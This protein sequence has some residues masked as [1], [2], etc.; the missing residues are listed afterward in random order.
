VHYQE[1]AVEVIGVLQNL[2]SCGGGVAAI[3]KAQIDADGDNKDMIPALQQAIVVVMDKHSADM[4]DL[5]AEGA[6]GAVLTVLTDL[7]ARVDSQPPAVPV[8]LQQVCLAHPS[9]VLRSYT[10]DR[11]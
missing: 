7:A 11:S 5:G 2:L 4:E 9:E 3:E 10:S 6:A 1:A 8:Q